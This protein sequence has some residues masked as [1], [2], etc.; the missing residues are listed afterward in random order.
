[1]SVETIVSDLSAAATDSPLKVKQA[2]EGAQTA[3]NPLEGLETYASWSVPDQ[4][5]YTSLGASTGSSNE[6]LA[7]AKKFVGT[8][9]VWGGTSPSG[10]DCSGFTQ[11][12]Y[13]QFGIDVPRVSYQQASSG[14]RISIA[15]AKAGDLVA[16]DNSS[17]N[18]GADHVGIY[19]GNGYVIHAPKPG[20]AVKI[21]KI[22]GNPWAVSMNVG[23]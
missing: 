10:F 22:W 17:R 12:V 23:G 19:L 1:M 4:E 7:F 11:Y 2:G 20:D 18:D 9:Y 5:T 3:T 13:R 16:W 15:D 21:S 14:P 6:L 8:P